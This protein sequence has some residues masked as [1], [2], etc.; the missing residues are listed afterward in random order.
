LCGPP[1]ALNNDGFL[2]YY[3]PLH[4]GVDLA[5][6]TATTENEDNKQGSKHGQ[7]KPIVLRLWFHCA[8]FLVARLRACLR[9][10]VSTTRLLYPIFGIEI[11]HLFGEFFKF[12]HNIAKVYI[13][14]LD[15]FRQITH[16]IKSGEGG[17]IVALAQDKGF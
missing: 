3:L 1:L 9:F 11:S 7:P 8:T 6:D 2:N 14:P 12:W 13:G 16:I 17:K 10:L 5:R 15:K 4:C